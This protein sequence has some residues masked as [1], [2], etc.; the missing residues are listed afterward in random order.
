M[1][2]VTGLAG[3]SL[4]LGGPD[5][6]H[7]VEVE[8]RM[9][10]AHTLTVD[11]LDDAGERLYSNAFDMPAETVQEDTEPFTGDPE[12]L[13]VT[14]D[15]DAPVSRNWP[16]NRCDERGVESAGGVDVVLTDEGLRTRLAC[17]TV[18]MTG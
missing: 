16:A 1:A 17:D 8:N 9:D 12:R 4:P 2:S 18:T 13:R 7:Y 6:A 11:V 3:C 15:G 10:T 5:L 14:V